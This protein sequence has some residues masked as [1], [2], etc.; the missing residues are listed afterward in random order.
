MANYRCPSCGANHKEFQPQCRLCGQSLSRDV[1]ETVLQTGATVTASRGG[2]KGLVLIGI[3]VVIAVVAVALVFG[4]VAGN[5]TLD[6]AKDAIVPG[7]AQDGWS[8]LSCSASN[9][10]ANPCKVPEGFDFSVTLPGDRTK[11]TSTFPDTKDGKL[12]IWSAKAGSDTLLTVGYAT[13]T[14]PTTGT[15]GGS[16]SR[17]ALQLFLRD[18]GEKWLTSQGV[19]DLT[20]KGG[21]TNVAGYPAYAYRA[22]ERQ[23]KIGE[24]PAYAQQALVLKGDKL[25]VVQTVSVYKDAEQFDRMVNSLQ[26]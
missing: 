25:F 6:Q 12:E 13:V 5:Q 2:M 15:T 26:L 10:P 18:L 1:G 16:V 3:L 7:G 9:D 8:Q 24:L 22:Q 21:E 23:L 19:T 4:L 11:S 14:P 20:V 17:A